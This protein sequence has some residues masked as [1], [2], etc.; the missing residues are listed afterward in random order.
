MDDVVGTGPNEHLMSDF[1]HMKTRLCF[2]GRG[3]V[4]QRTRY[5][6]LFWSLDSQDKSEGSS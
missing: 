3:G 1:E 4:A 6:S 5:N 2:D